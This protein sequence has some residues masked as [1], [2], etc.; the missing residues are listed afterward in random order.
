[1]NGL[2]CG[3]QSMSIYSAV[4]IQYQRVTGGRTDGRPAYIDKTC[5]TIAI[6]ARIQMDAQVAQGRPKHMWID[7][8]KMWTN[9]DTYEVIKS[10]AQNRQ[11]WRTYSGVFR[12]SQGGNP[13]L[14]TTYHPP[15]TLLLSIPYPPSSLPLPFRGPLPPNTARGSGERASSTSGSGRSSAARRFLVHFRL[16]R[17]LLV[18]CH[19]CCS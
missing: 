3:E 10:I 8:I 12:I 18:T 2:S 17:T 1:M 6:D 19:L 9:L 15:L 7:D 11:I 5:F 4:L 16:K 13:P 14:P